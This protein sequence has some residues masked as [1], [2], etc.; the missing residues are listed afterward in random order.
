M[1]VVTSEG[2][3]VGDGMPS[4]GSERQGLML[5]FFAPSV[6]PNR[7]CCNDHLKIFHDSNR[8]LVKVKDLRLSNLAKLESKEL[9]SVQVLLPLL[10]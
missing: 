1:F 7:D 3:T 4:L 10:H 5:L 6:K 9:R 8:D 2:E